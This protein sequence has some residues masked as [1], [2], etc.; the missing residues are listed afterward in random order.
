MR[1]AAFWITSW[2]GVDSAYTYSVKSVQRSWPPWLGIISVSK[3]GS[4]LPNPRLLLTA[5]HHPGG[6]A[7]ILGV[8][9]SVL[10]PQQKHQSLANT[11]G[12]LPSRAAAV[13]F[14]AE[15]P[16]ASPRIYLNLP[17]NPIFFGRSFFVI[18]C[19]LIIERA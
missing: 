13:G 4:S 15:I 10:A 2:T 16:R 3:L 12:K 14:F 18:V 17:T 6:P 5:P 19:L 7:G 11:L 9:A 8:G 1:A